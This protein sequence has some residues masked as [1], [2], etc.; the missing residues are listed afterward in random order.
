MKYAKLNLKMLLEQGD[1]PL[2]L[3]DEPDSPDAETADDEAADDE[4]DTATEEEEGVEI[5]PDDEVA[6]RK[7]LEA[8]VD[9]M[10][11]DFELAAVKSAKVNENIRSLTFLLTEADAIEFDVED[12]AT[13]VARLIDNYETLLDIESAIYYRAIAILTNNYGEE[14]TNAF[15]DIMQSRYNFNFGDVRFDPVKDVAPLALGSGDAAGG[16]A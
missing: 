16:G 5:D 13:N 4:G 14:I 3:G 7:P 15:R 9:N 12:F 8:Q 6:L 10:L 2:D 11:A 1:D